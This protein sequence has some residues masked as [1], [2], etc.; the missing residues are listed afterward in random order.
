MP[1]SRLKSYLAGHY[2]ETVNPRLKG[3]P[4]EQLASMVHVGEAD[5][6]EVCAGTGFLGRIIARSFPQARISALDLSPELIAEGRRRARGLHNLGFTRGDVT[7][8]PYPDSSFELVLAAFGLSELSSEARSDC[9]AEINRVLTK[10]GRL[11][12]ADIDQPRRHAG[13]FRAYR[14]LSRGRRAGDVLGSG[15]VRQ[16]ESHGF[17]TV[18]HL[19]RQ[20]RLFPFQIIVAHKTA[21]DADG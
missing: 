3:S 19:T 7:A 21:A 15:L 13:L 17:G 16:I 6:L 5:I 4:H 12:V 2:L 14:H 1:T 18:R 10:S 8:M 9:L 11:L 20:G